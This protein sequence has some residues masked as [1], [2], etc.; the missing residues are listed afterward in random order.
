[1]RKSE[2]SQAGFK[3]VS[4]TVIVSS[5]IG[6]ALCLILLLPI[7]AMML[8][9]VLDESLSDALLYVV[10]FISALLMAVYST[11]KVRSRYIPVGTATGVMMF[12]FLCLLGILFLDRFTFSEGGTSIL[13][14]AA[15]GG[16]VGGF[17]SGSLLPSRRK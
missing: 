3:Q 8:S 2:N 6:V 16:V 9:G 14:C 17:A 10:V 11:R 13:L 15:L 12:I 5:L 7:T 1:M 4:F